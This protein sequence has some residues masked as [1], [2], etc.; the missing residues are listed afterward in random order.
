MYR[1]V[2]RFKR[3]YIGAINSSKD[4]ILFLDGDMELI[5]GWIEDAIQIIEN[6][7]EVAG[8]V[9]IRYNVI[10]YPNNQEKIIQINYPEKQLK[11]YLLWRRCIT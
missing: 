6:Y 1:K 2:N 9:G 5:E 7:E 4:Y 3:E 10:V 11:S 8:I